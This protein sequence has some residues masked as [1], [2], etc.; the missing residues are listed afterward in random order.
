MT[1]QVHLRDLVHLDVQ[2]PQ[3]TV[4]VLIPTEWL[5]HV[6]RELR[7]NLERAVSLELELGGFGLQVCP[8]EPDSGP[9]LDRRIHH[10]S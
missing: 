6:V 3:P 4:E 9:P 1:E 8:I 2:Y 10:E 5:L 7:K